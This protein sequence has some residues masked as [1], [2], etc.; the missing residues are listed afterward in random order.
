[1]GKEDNLFAEA[2]LIAHISVN[3][4]SEMRSLNFK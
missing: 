1:M 3:F 4:H 2:T